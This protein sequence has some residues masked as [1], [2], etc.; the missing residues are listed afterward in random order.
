MTQ[1]LHDPVQSCV[2][3][4]DIFHHNNPFV[5]VVAGLDDNTPLECP[6]VLV[7][8]TVGVAEAEAVM[9]AGHCTAA[10]AVVVVVDQFAAAADYSVAE[11][12][13]FV[14]VVVVVAAAAAA[15]E[16]VAAVAGR[17]RCPYFS[18]VQEAL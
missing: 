2:V 12:A 8:A 14:V 17:Q 6:I 7:V 13:L 3:V 9:A 1:E 10:A 5:V 15:L 11:A 4:L 18:L 16:K